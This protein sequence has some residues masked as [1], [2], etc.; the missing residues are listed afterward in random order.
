MSSACQDRGLLRQ[1]HQDPSGSESEEEQA[2]LALSSTRCAPQNLQGGI[3][4]WGKSLS[5]SAPA[6]GIVDRCCQPRAVQIHGHFCPKM[7][8][9]LWL[10]GQTLGGPSVLHTE[11]CCFPFQASFPLSVLPS[12]TS[13]HLCF[14]SAFPGGGSLRA[15]PVSSC[16]LYCSC[17]L[18]SCFCS[19]SLP[20]G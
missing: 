10:R 18:C 4:F 2:E 3:F 13:P 9:W 1:L 8:Q 12:L 17:I 15:G 6:Q 14:I 7:L 5:G 16:L 19:G 11:G 20:E